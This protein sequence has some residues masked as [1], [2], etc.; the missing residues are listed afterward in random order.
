M[1]L[2]SLKKIVLNLSFFS[3]VIYVGISVGKTGN[4]NLFLLKNLTATAGTGTNLGI[5]TDIAGSS[6]FPG[7]FL[8]P[9]DYLTSPNGQYKL[10]YQNDG[11]LVLYNRFSGNLPVW[12]SNTS[13][14]SAGMVMLDPQGMLRMYDVDWNQVWSG[15]RSCNGGY[16]K[17]LDSGEFV[18][19]A[20]VE[21]DKVVWRTKGG[22][23]TYLPGFYPC[24][25][26]H[27]Q[28]W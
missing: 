8:L 1:M 13:G 25:Y 19:N 5:T 20:P 11:N 18:V 17:V 14:N 16:I 3:F 4:S 24:N 22:A 23:V 26:Q 28:W 15:G 27:Y 21:G 9:N 10:I 7:Q 12:S 2:S 6:L